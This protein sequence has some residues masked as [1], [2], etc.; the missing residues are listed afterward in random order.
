MTDDLMTEP[1]SPLRA[2]AVRGDALLNRWGLRGQASRDTALAVAVAVFSTGTLWSLLVSM[3]ALEGIGLPVGTGLGL[4]AVVCVQSLVLC[5]RRRYPVACLCAA[6]ALQV[7]TVALLPPEVGLQGPALVVAAYTCG[8]LLAPGRLA[9]AVTVVTLLHWAAGSLVAG[10]WAPAMP[11]LPFSVAPATASAGLLLSGVA[12]FAVPALV[13][14]YVRTQRSY[15]D[16]RRLRAAEAMRAQRER[17][18][19]AVRAERTRMARELHDIAAHHLSGMVVQAGAAERL[20][21]RD[22]GAAREAM[23]W[24]RAQGRQTLE[25]L[26]LAVGALREPGEEEG[27]HHRGEPGARGAPVPGLSSLDRLV[28]AERGLGADIELVRE[29]EPRPLPPVADVTA[30]RV[31]QESLS[32]ARD[33]APGAGVRLLVRYGPGRVALEIGNGPGQPGTAERG[34]RGLGLV[35][36]RERSQLVGATLEAGPTGDGGWQVRW[37]VAVER[38]ETA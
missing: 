32:N 19:A 15:A 6:T 34:H 27:L 31:V 17:V 9:V 37:E 28:T 4:T 33:H 2:A 12:V 30:Y 3:E 13:G 20:V 25:N 29:G 22:D 7:L 36:M 5:A 21:G 16:L 26:R 24:V 14:A 10:V 38:E 18:E 1:A 23:S 8:T 35:G 11:P